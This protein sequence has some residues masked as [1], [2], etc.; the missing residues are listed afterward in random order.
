MPK[1]LLNVGEQ[2]SLPVIVPLTSY[3]EKTAVSVI[4]NQFKRYGSFDVGSPE[5]KVPTLVKSDVP[6]CSLNVPTK[7]VN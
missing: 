4:F 3:S 1:A 2:S 7:E 5:R 6:N